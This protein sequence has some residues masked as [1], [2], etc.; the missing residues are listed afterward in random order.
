MNHSRAQ[1]WSEVESKMNVKGK[2]GIAFALLLIIV[3][4]LSFSYIVTSPSSSG[5]TPTSSDYSAATNVAYVHI[6]ADAAGWDEHYHNVN[7]SNPVN[8][9]IFVKVDTTLYFNVTEEDGAP[10]TLTLGY[11]GTTNASANLPIVNGNIS[12]SKMLG[13]YKSYEPSVSYTVL[14]TA[15]ITTTIGHNSQGKFPFTKAGVYSYWCTI[16]PFS[17]LG[18]IIV[19]SYQ[20]TSIDVGHSAPI[21]NNLIPHQVKNFGNNYIS[22]LNTGV[23]TK[24]ANFGVG[25]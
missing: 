15:Q 18:V 4:G 12:N 3:V 14:S 11:L 8:P 5:L 22:D 13:S 1:A 23:T 2:G 10:H 16:H 6:Y 20:N 21:S 19:G 9:T 17:M 25:Y 24:T 7:S